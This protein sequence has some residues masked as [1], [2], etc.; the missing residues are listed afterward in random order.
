MAATELHEVYQLERALES[1]LV[2]QLLSVG[3]PAVVAHTAPDLVAPPVV[4]VSCTVQK[5]DDVLEL[6]NG[7]PMEKRWSGTVGISLNSRRSDTEQAELFHERLGL[8]RQ[9]IHDVASINALM[10][11]HELATFYEGTTQRSFNTDL[12]IDIAETV[13]SFGLAIKPDA[14]PEPAQP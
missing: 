11:Y 7:V 12:D 9:V 3:L 10:T 14:W 1:A 6:I 2:T 8:I 13:I 5:V 4:F